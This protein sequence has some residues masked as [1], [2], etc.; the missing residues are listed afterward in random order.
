MPASIHDLPRELFPFILKK[1]CDPGVGPLDHRHS[2]GRQC[3]SLLRF[4]MIF[5][6][7]CRDWRQI[8][9]GMPIFWSTVEFTNFLRPSPVEAHTCLI[10]VLRYS[11]AHLRCICLDFSPLRGFPA[12][13]QVINETLHTIVELAPKTWNELCI[14]VAEGDHFDSISDYFSWA[15]G[16]QQERLAS[17][18]TLRLNYPQDSAGPSSPFIPQDSRGNYRR[19]NDVLPTYYFD[20]SLFK[21]VNDIYLTNTRLLSVG[22]R[23]LRIHLNDWTNVIDETVLMKTEGDRNARSQ[24]VRHHIVTNSAANMINCPLNPTVASLTIVLPDTGFKHFPFLRPTVGRFGKDIRSIYRTTVWS[25]I[26]ALGNSAPSL[27]FI[28]LVDTTSE[29]WLTFLAFLKPIPIDPSIPGPLQMPLTNLSWKHIVVRFAPDHR[30]PQDIAPLDEDL[31]VCLRSKLRM[32]F[33]FQTKFSQ[34]TSQEDMEDLMKECLRKLTR[35]MLPG[36]ERFD[37]YDPRGWHSHLDAS[38]IKGLLA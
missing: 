1:A 7:V 4:A 35:R 32:G 25:H 21:S 24:M 38:I 13:E 17:L 37:W 2:H 16:A 33:D 14:T 23:A 20:T 8:V 31:S 27:D 22:Q 29:A 36:L 9:M 5:S 19:R 15:S 3:P 34:S 28:E 26:M 18:A 6:S 12:T 11:N 10:D 30:Q